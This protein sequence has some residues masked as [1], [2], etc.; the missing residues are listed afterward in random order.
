MGMQRCI[1]SRTFFVLILGRA[2]GLESGWRSDT[3][4]EGFFSLWDQTDWKIIERNRAQREKKK[5][6]GKWAGMKEATHCISRLGSNP[7]PFIFFKQPDLLSINQHRVCLNELKA[8]L[9]KSL[10]S[11]GCLYSPFTF[12]GSR[13]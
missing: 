6:R 9:T 3:A 10:Y 7:C 13:P 8:Y 4:A 2:E 5:K 12:L 11:C 1:F